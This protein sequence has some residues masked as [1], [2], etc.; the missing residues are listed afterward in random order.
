[1]SRKRKR[2]VKQWIA[3]RRQYTHLNALNEVQLLDP[4]DSN[5]YFQINIDNYNQLLSMVAPLGYEKYT[6]ELSLSSST[7]RST[8][9][10]VNKH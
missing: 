8:L 3:K 10:S 9:L 5:N 4:K 7:R 6:G 2:W 1:M